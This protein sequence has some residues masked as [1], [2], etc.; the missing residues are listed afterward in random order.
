MRILVD[1]AEAARVAREVYGV[2]GSAS[3]LPGERDL[4]FH[5]RGGDGEYVL[6]FHPPEMDAAELELATAALEHV[7][8]VAEAPRLVRTPD[9]ESFGRSGDRAVSL[10]TWLEGRPWA[11]CGPHG[12]ER[13]ESLG[14]AV[15]RLDRA[16]V[17]FRHPAEDRTLL[18]NMAHASEF[19]AH[20]E[21]V[22]PER[23]AAVREIFERHESVVAPKLERLPHQVIHNDANELNILV[24]DDG[25][26]SGLIDFGDAVRSPR[27]AGLAVACAYAMLGEDEPVRA[28]APVVAGYDA[29]WPLRPEELEMLFDLIRLR[30][31]MSVVMA[32]WQSANDPE[33]E[34]LLVSQDGVARTLELLRAESRDL[35]HFRF[36]DACGWDAVPWSRH[37][38]QF[39]E[40]GRARPAPVLPVDVAGGDAVVLDL[41][42]GGF[43]PLDPAEL[44]AACA[45]IEERIERAGVEFAIGLYREDRTIYR[46]PQFDLGDG[47]RR[48]LHMALDVWLAAGTPVFA[49]LD[50]VAAVVTNNPAPLDFGGLVLL[51]HET[52]EG[53]PFWTLYGHLDPESL[54]LSVGDE[55]I[56]GTQ[57]ARLGAVGVNGGWPPHLHLQLVTSLCDLGADVPGVAPAR[58][59]EPLGEH[60]PGPEPPDRPAGTAMRHAWRGRAPEIARRRR[61]NLSGALSIAYREPLHIVRGE[62]AYLY[63]DAGNAWLD[64]VNNVAHVG[65][66]HPRVVEAGARQMARPQHE[67]PL[68]ARLDRRVHPPPRCLAAGSP[69]RRLP[70]QLGLGGERSRPAPRDRAHRARR[71]ARSRPRLPRPPLEHGRAQP[72][73]VRRARWPGEAR[74]DARVRAARAVPG[75]PPHGRAGSRPALRGIGARCTPRRTPRPRSSPSR[76]RACAGQI[77]FP[78]GYLAAA[79]EHVR[80]AGGVCVSDEVQVGL[81]RIGEH[82]WG[83]ELQGVVPDIVTLGKPIG[84]GHPLAAVVTTPEIAAS[85]VTGMEYFNTF[86]GN[87]VS[88]EI[89][90]AVLDVMQD[91]ALQANAAR[92]RWAPARRASRPRRQPSADRRRA[93]P[94]PLHRRRA[95]PRSARRARPRPPR[96]TRSR[97]R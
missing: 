52:D 76:C 47:R 85:F 38:R 57:I 24:G 30:L 81:G 61:G 68:P 84:N 87:P 22:A 66:C 54:D 88:C 20:L 26:V 49:A 39:F 70:R 34:Y 65:H 43:D 86:G 79:F 18:W 94:R 25:A 15:A 7:A 32:A 3:P 4:N 31:A 35:A 56:A 62:G 9:G 75:P 21:L 67:H 92:G 78:D 23:Q 2:D 12:A 19:A 36:R 42:A 11:E 59:G 8:G 28:V 93:R 1:A 33:N 48:S 91:E 55:V 37:V 45:D 46:A 13:R 40:S 17:G 77:V 82:M 80:A 74:D 96:P 95:E 60:Q 10:L 90:L 73:Q 64:L 71:R 89:G 41:G 29:E 53:V 16:L 69:A 97:R 5:L 63:D 83:F 50:G 27:V 6:K 72:V 44:A 51:E 58:R 14:R